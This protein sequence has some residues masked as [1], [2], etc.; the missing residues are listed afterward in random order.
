M[1]DFRFHQTGLVILVAVA[2]LTGCGHPTVNISASRSAPPITA[3]QNTTS[4]PGIPFYVKHG[5]CKLETVWL[6]PQFAVD[7]KIAQPGSASIIHHLVLSQ[8][9]F[10]SVAAQKLMADLG[11]MQ[12]ASKPG[13]P[14]P[15]DSCSVAAAW[16]YVEA[17]AINPASK[18]LCDMTEAPGCRELADAVRQ[19][20]VLRMANKAAIDVQVDYSQVYYM[21]T[22]TPWIGNASASAKLAADGTLTDASAQVTDQT[23]STILSTVSSLAGDLT[24]FGAAALAVPAAPATP[25]PAAAAHTSSLTCPQPPADWPMPS[26]DLTYKVDIDPQIF[27]HDHTRFDPAKGADLAACVAPPGGVTDGNVLI[28]KKQSDSG[29]GDKGGYKFSGQ[30]TPPKSGSD[31]KK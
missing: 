21:N 29:D 26:K 19:G 1:Q 10:S 8:S 31:D 15:P 9:G 28:T 4:L 2:G 24:T 23:W 14:Q 25:P 12:A 20:D 27:I 6:E 30:V 5:V 17:S 13:A 3:A 22:R 16:S 18:P 11:R 7:V